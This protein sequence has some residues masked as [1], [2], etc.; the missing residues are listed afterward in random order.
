MLENQNNSLEQS[1]ELVSYWQ[2]QLSGSPLLLELPTD[3]PRQSSITFK[4]QTQTI[5]LSDKSIESLQIVA[6]DRDVEIFTVLLA[7]FKVLI[8]RYS[9]RQD[10]P[11]GSPIVS[12][13][14]A[15]VDGLGGCGFDNIVLRTDLSGNPTFL[16]V[17]QRI[18]K[19]VADARAHQNLSFDRLL[20]ALEIERSPSYH[21][22]FQVMFSLEQTK[23]DLTVVPVPSEQID[24]IENLDLDQSVA[25]D[26]PD[27]QSSSLDLALRLAETDAGISGHFEYSTD[28]FAVETI[29]RMVMHF[30]TLLESIIA[31]PAQR[32]DEL[33]LLTAAERQQLLV[34]WNQTQ[35][36]YPNLCIHQLFEAQVERTPNNIA[37]I[38]EDQQL[39]YR[40]LNSQANQLAH[41]L[42]SLGV[43]SGVLVGLYVERSLAMVVGIWGILK[44]GG[45]Y[46]PLDPAYPQDRVA[47]I[48]A[49]SDAKVLIADPQ[50][51]ASLP[52]HQAEVVSF[53]TNKELIEQQPRSNPIADTQPDNL[54]YVI[55]TSGS[56][57]NPKGVEVCHSSQANLLNYL[58]HSPGLTSADT[59]L[60]VT[61][62]CFDTSTADMFLPLVVGAKIVLVSSEVAAD[63]FQLLA[64]LTDSGATF[65]QA[66]PVSFRLLLAA[67]WQGSPHLRVVS[68]GEALSRNLADLLLDRVAELWDLYGPT[69]TTVWS[70]GSKINGLRRSAD[71]QGALELIGRPIANTQAYILDRYL[72]PVPIGIRGE[73]HIGG[74]CL[75][76]GYL[77]RPE[78]TAEK[79]IANPFSDAPNAR[80]YKTGDLARYLPDGNIEYIGRIDNQIKIRGFR[81][82]LGEIE[83]LLVKHPGVKE[84]TVVVREDIP[85]DRRL[86]AYIV[87][88]SLSE[89]LRQ[90][91]RSPTISDLREFLASKLPHYM[92]PT[93][94]VFLDLLPLTPNGKIDRR[95]LPIPIYTRQLEG[96]FVASQDEVELQLTKIWKQVLGIEQIG[97]EDNFFELGGHSL[98][99]V[100]AI[101][102]VE[103]IW[104][105]KLPLATFLA[106]PTIREF[107]NVIRQERGSTAWSSLVSIESRGSRPPLFCIH[108]VGGNVLEYYP[109][110]TYLGLEQPM[111]GLQSPG[112]DGV[113]APLTRIEEMA[114]L[115]IQ[116]IQR[117]Q[118]QGPYLL[119]GYS[120]G[121]LVAFEIARKLDLQG[122]KIGLLALL[123]NEAPN[124]PEIRPSLLK[125]VEIHV[126]NLQR[127]TISEKFK[128]VKDRFMFRII[129]KNSEEKFLLDNW[130]EPLPPEYLQ[131]LEA[132]FQAG[133]DY[134]G[135]FYPG[136]VTLFRSYVQS[137]NK[138]L[139]P[140]LGWGHLVGGGV[141]VC[142]LPGNHNN[143]LKEPYIKILALKLKLYLERVS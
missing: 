92:V 18:K 86:V 6:R 137:V 32:I 140:D 97:I 132:N 90:P 19:V 80:L 78:L 1:I 104:H 62:I 136:K 53:V 55:Y 41:Y 72:Q 35:A 131:V 118:P 82:E 33:P 133:R 48:L 43:G 59:L 100:R 130:V 83:G 69:E 40:E 60:A 4:T 77:H 135:K 139:L 91:D 81:I 84:V 75:A 126:R 115:Y 71:F 16:E 123:D 10:I 14:E 38:F 66:T 142:D 34:A 105:Q 103:K 124:L 79:F 117:L 15:T 49:D 21:P 58:Q 63:G 76:K 68:T 96:E 120:F 22:L 45:A 46:V 98:L 2:Q 37:V 125:S 27:R 52:R 109:L 129:Y 5:V 107:A 93:A 106:A 13:N 111:Y 51:L 7:V 110:S 11:I 134:T 8:Y 101:S 108:P 17:L 36:D 138:A 102:A 44:A 64:K 141:E 85:D 74:D 12:Q 88:N 47:Y 113:A 128:Y 31:N 143:L 65:L 9:D 119:L 30:Q 95:A 29:E 112:L 3:K 87:A 73:L 61:T 54:A 25:I 20:E 24:T 122:Q 39:T 94:F 114:D 89:R 23:V 28:L 42:R 67:G 50:L 57:G 116:E 127:L 70:T 26:I 99:A 56:T 121:G